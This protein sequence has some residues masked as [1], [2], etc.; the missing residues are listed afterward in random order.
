MTGWRIKILTA[1]LPSERS[2]ECEPVV[3]RRFGLVLDQ[4]R[5]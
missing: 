1:T 2:L 5:L 3:A 4:A